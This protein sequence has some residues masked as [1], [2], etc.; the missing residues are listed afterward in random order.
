MKTTQL[1]E[2][3]LSR[4]YAARGDDKELIL[5]VWSQLGFDL[6]PAQE[7]KF[8]ELPSTET[9]RRVRQKLQENGKYLPSKAV[10]EFRESKS[11]VI[12]QNAPSASPEHVE[13]VLDNAYLKQQSLI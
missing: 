12:Q 9:I 3:V 1:I 10:Q 11:Q 8:L 6:T 2:Q 5:S 13:E 7:Q 4:N